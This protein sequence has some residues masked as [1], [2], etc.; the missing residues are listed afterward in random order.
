MR[1][2]EQGSRKHTAAL[3]TLSAAAATAGVRSCFSMDLRGPEQSEGDKGSRNHTAALL[4]PVHCSRQ[5]WL[6]VLL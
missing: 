3:T 4:L 1:S 6:Q 5:N 2:G